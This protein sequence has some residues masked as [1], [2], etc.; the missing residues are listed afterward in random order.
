MARPATLGE[1][2]AIRPRMI[3]THGRPAI[4]EN[5]AS[6]GRPHFTVEPCA[7]EAPCPRCGSTASHCRRPSG[8]D[9][10][11]WHAERA[12]AFEALCAER[13]T[14]GLPPGRPMARHDPGPVRLAVDVSGQGG[15]GAVSYTHL[16][17]PTKRI[18]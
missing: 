5:C 1:Y 4:L 14:A 6:C 12:A 11:A 17:L 18:V 7:H 10:D 3:D 8:H 15:S 9:A 2:L 16:T 13:E